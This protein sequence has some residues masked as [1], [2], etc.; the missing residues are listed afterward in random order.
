MI[1]K[2]DALKFIKPGVKILTRITY[3]KQ[4]ETNV[5]TIAKVIDIGDNIVVF[6]DKN[7]RVRTLRLEQIINIKELEIKW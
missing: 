6:L 3:K 5:Y 1:T 7:D 4:E 2:N